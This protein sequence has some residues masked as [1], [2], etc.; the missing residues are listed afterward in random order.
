MKKEEI[1]LIFKETKEAY[2]RNLDNIDKIDSKIVQLFTFI[3][4]LILVFINFIKFPLTQILVVVYLFTIIIFISALFILIKS[5]KPK[6][7]GAIDYNKLIIEYNKGSY[8][9]ISLL[10]ALSGRNAED[11]NSIKNNKEEKSNLF[12]LSSYL[13]LIG[14]I[15][16]IILKI[17]QGG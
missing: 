16:I 17:F 4:T 9:D 6:K 7:Y 5:Y 3:T 14:I 11:I 8:N 12:S 1:E 15:L 13:T 2:K 10:K